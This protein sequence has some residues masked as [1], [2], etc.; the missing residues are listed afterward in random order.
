MRFF[1][2]L[3]LTYLLGFINTKIYNIYYMK[4]IKT[5]ESFNNKVLDDYLQISK[6]NELPM[7]YKKGLL[8]WLYEG[9]IVDWSVD[10]ITDWVSDSNVN[11]LI[12]D[13]SKEFGDKLFMYGLVPTNLIISRLVDWYEDEG[14]MS[15][16]DYHRDYQSTNKVDY[17]DTLYPIIVNDSNLEYI[18]DGWHR[19]NYYISRGYSD[20]PV[21]KFI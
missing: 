15:F 11:T 3:F 6:F 18:D 7:D 20:I 9:D 8:I 17:E 16:G 10:N 4:K 19:F 2:N 12:D 5:Y 14:Y 13:Y 1:I 21:I